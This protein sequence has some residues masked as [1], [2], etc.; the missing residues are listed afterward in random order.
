MPLLQSWGQSSAL[1][2]VV[3]QYFLVLLLPFFAGGFLY[4]G[5]SDLLPE[6]HEKNPQILTVISCTSGFILVF[7]LTYVL[8]NMLYVWLGLVG[9]N[10]IQPTK[11][12]DRLTDARCWIVRPLGGFLSFN[13]ST[14]CNRRHQKGGIMWVDRGKVAVTRE[15]VVMARV[16]SVAPSSWERTGSRNYWI[17]PEGGR[18]SKESRFCNLCSWHKTW[19]PRKNKGYQNNRKSSK[20]ASSQISTLTELP[21][22]G[23][24]YAIIFGLSAATV[25]SQSL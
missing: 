8:S 2:I 20:R 4:L 16:L 10:L 7:I 23:S 3:P 6:A 18:H 15:D 25:S 24:G 19:R 5:A 13:R 22:G 21:E 12:D 17:E 14:V 9:L 11:N 1:F